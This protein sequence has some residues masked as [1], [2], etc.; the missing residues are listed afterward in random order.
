MIFCEP[1]NHKH[2]LHSN[3]FL[4]NTMQRLLSLYYDDYCYHFYYYHQ[5]FVQA[6][7]VK[8]GD[9]RPFKI[10]SSLPFPHFPST[11][12]PPPHFSSF[13]SHFVS[14][15]LTY[16]PPSYFIFA[17]IGLNPLLPLT[18][19]PHFLPP[20]KLLYCP[21]L[22]IPFTPH[23]Q[24]LPSSPCH[25]LSLLLPFLPTP[26]LLPSNSH[27]LLPCPFPPLILL[28]L[29]SHFTSDSSTFSSSSTW[30]S[31]Y[32]SSSSNFSISTY[33][34]SSASLHTISSIIS[35]MRFTLGQ[36]PGLPGLANQ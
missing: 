18:S 10:N 9:L 19:Y 4:Y 14:P 3:R 34:F 30:Y 7:K 25:S 29:S 32:I 26:Y 6:R 2:L 11:S 35:A 5:M 27:S 22:P 24:S 13:P 17:P 33:P 28:F 15:S 23:S 12:T 8:F 31:C 36:S 21:S 1:W 20:L 16:T